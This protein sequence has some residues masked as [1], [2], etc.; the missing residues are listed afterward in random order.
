M[1]W[2]M[3][4]C[5]GTMLSSLADSMAGVQT[6]W[7]V[8]HTN[9]WRRVDDI[10]AGCARGTHKIRYTYNFKYCCYRG[11]NHGEMMLTIEGHAVT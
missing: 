2:A 8:P 11:Q 10:D 9:P 6:P 3:L 5:L 7:Q 4:P 1:P